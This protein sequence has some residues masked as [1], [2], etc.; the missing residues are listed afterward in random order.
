V[1]GRGPGHE[2]ARDL[3]KRDFTAAAPNRR[4]VADFTH[5]AT[6]GGTVY[7]AFTADVFSRMITGWATPATSARSWYRTPWTWRSVLAGRQSG[8][9]DMTL[10]A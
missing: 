5:V 7:V 1:P 8:Q 9:A 10:V 4:W 6:L 2:R 3:L